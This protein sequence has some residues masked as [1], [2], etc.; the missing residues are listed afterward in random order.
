MKRNV[1]QKKKDGSG[2]MKMAS[3]EQVIV[4]VYKLKTYYTSWRI[5]Y[6]LVTVKKTKVAG[7]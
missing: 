1:W 7:F 6:Y 4:Y 5:F 2:N 3:K